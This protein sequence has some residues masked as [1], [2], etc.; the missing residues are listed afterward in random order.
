VHTEE[1]D[2]KNVL[3]LFTT[4]TIERPRG[5]SYNLKKGELPHH[6]HKKRTQKKRQRVVFLIENINIKPVLGKDCLPARGKEVTS[7]AFDE[8]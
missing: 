3:L 8:F 4:V 7:V 1:I 5:H 6:H 2:R